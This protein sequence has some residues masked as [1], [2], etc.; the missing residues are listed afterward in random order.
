[1]DYDIF[2]SYRRVD[3]ELARA[4][5]TALEARGVGVWWDQKIEGGVDWRDAIVENLISSDMLVILFS[6][7]CN[8]SKQLKKE[9]AL[10]DD[11]DKDVIPVLIEDTKP[12]GHFLYEMA[13]RN[14][15]QIHPNPENK[16]NELADRLTLLAEASPGGLAGTKPEP[17]PEAAPVEAAAQ[18]PLSQQD[19]VD[20]NQ[21]DIP[22][23]TV[24]T[25]PPKTPASAP[26]ASPFAGI[27][28]NDLVARREALKRE[29]ALLEIAEKKAKLKA[30]GAKPVAKKEAASPQSKTSRG[31]VKKQYR[32]FLPFKWIDLILL[33]PILYFIVEE[34]GGGFDRLDFTDISEMTEF[35]AMISVSLAGV[36]ALVFP[37]RYYMRNLRMKE[38]AKEYAKSSLA[39]YALLWLSGLT[40]AINEGEIGEVVGVCLGF[41]GLWVA[42]GVGAFALY[43]LMHFQRSV[44]NFKSNVDKI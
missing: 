5:V 41:G 28:P 13:A 37:I 43:G 15:I 16:I 19:A 22:Q 38:A 36:G 17:I 26:P 8:N 29:E 1:M 39:L 44:R 25:P 9:L 11:M 3:Q 27:N 7:E 18:P 35:M 21:P 34:T 31:K 30:G 10:A 14:W 40:F 24:T 23:Q 32:N 6:E 33:S 42:F 12:K 20:T 2:L 4:L